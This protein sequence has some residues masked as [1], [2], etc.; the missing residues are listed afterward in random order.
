MEDIQKKIQLLKNEMKNDPDV[1]FEWTLLPEN[2]GIRSEGYKKYVYSKLDIT[3]DILDAVVRL[4]TN[5]HHEDLSRNLSEGMEV[6]KLSMRSFGQ[7]N[8]YLRLKK[9]NREWYSGT[10][11]QINEHGLEK[12][13]GKLAWFVPDKYVAKFGKLGV[14]LKSVQNALQNTVPNNPEPSYQPPQLKPEHF[15]YVL[16]VQRVWTD[17][18]YEQYF[19][20]CIR[21]GYHVSEELQKKYDEIQIRKVYRGWAATPDGTPLNV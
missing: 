16:P 8:V 21:L 3:D 15:K 13:V 5:P 6:A 20:S 11:R 4:L 14:Q 18:D 7:T 19:W 10:I 2:N 17:N 1:S 12:L 9:F